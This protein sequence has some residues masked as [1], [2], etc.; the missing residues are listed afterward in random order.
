RWTEIAAHG[1]RTAFEARSTTIAD[2]PEWQVEA[3]LHVKLGTARGRLRRVGTVAASLAALAIGV[4][5]GVLLR[6]GTSA[7]VARGADADRVAVPAIEPFVPAAPA[8]VPAP[9]PPIEVDE[10]AL[11]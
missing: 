6:S 11:T 10:L 4:A 8:A 2:R 1:A 7:H 3:K 5:A 9:A